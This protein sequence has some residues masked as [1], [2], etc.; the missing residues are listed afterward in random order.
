MIDSEGNTFWKD[1]ISDIKRNPS[2]A[3]CVPLT[4]ACEG[5]ENAASNLTFLFSFPCKLPIPSPFSEV[6]GYWAG[7][8]V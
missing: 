3:I 6:L 2:T 7:S 1:L 5:E 8:S 4:V